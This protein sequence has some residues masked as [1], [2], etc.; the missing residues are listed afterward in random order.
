MTGTFLLA[1]VLFPVVVLVCCGGGGLLVRRLSGGELSA[2]LVVPVGF[3]LLVVVCA[4]ATSISWLAPAGGAIVLALAV[5][6]YVAEARAGAPRSCARARALL[7]RG[8]SGWLWP[9]LAALIAFAAVGGPALLTGTPTWAGYTRIVDIAFQMDFA[10]HLAEAGRS[11]AP[12]HSSF[13]VS[14]DKLTS[15]GYPGGGQATLGVMAALI[16]TDVAWC[17]QAYL[18][19]TAAIGALAAFSLLSR[20][21]RIRVLCALGAA[22]VIQPNILYGYTLEGGIKEIT[23]AALLLAAVALLVERL[24]GEGSRWSMLPAAVAISAAF[25]SFSAGVA[26]WLGL[27]LL[28]LLIVTFVRSRYRRRLLASWGLFL[29]S[30]AALSIPSFFA[31]AE[32]ASSAEVSNPSLGNLAAAV[33]DWSSAGVWLTGDYRFP[34]VHVA[35]THAFDV[36]VIALAVLGIIFALR[37]HYWALGILGLG[38]PIALYYWVASAGPWIQLKAFTITSAFALLL[39]FFGAG[40]LSGLHPRLAG[41]LGS[42][43]AVVMAGVVLYGN[44][45]IYHDTSLAPAA[46]YRDLAA[47]GSAY[48]GQGPLMFPY[49]D[50]YAEYFL[51]HEDPDDLVDPAYK[52]FILASGVSPPP[53]AVSFSWDLN[54]LSASFVQSFRLIVLARSPVANRPP[55]NYDLVKQTHYFD[56]WRRDR[57]S[58]TVV[59][60]LPLSGLP[61]ERTQQFCSAFIT[62][63]RQAGPGAE[64]AYAQSSPGTV[65]GVTQGPHPDYW[66]TVG[67]D[68]VISYGAGTAQIPVTLPQSALFDIW[69]QGSVG[70]P[71]AVYVDGRHLTNI[72]WEERYPN[73]FL[74]L[75][76]RE[77]AR[78]AHTVRIVR[79]NG[80]LHPGSGDPPTDTVGRTIGAVVFSIDDS[81]SGRVHVAPPSM[82]AQVCAAPVGYQ[83][84]EVLKPGGAPANAIRAQR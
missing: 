55:S 19:V 67:P 25:A 35:A 79:G 6:G 12:L 26:P 49:F 40:A 62:V 32:L 43:A 10:K 47:I 70:R 69:V 71:L 39:A 18:A 8:A 45:I 2:G 37:R 65:T 46:R 78:G 73:Q 20:A 64:V 51:R 60:H 28:G 42:L 34:L 52:G 33:P 27:V 48:A 16:R 77:L 61:H 68:T 4:F 24:P 36:L 9:T 76:Q 81:S 31:V 44:A 41:W 1:W 29:A 15:V 30:I 82:A 63:A 23:T 53:G 7:S 56:V 80:S 84:L 22:V 59:V 3:A 13:D 38:T 74:L 57:P 66:R 54:Q 58:S 83:W 72:G 50:E 11:V 14:L 5:V 21:I 75:G 17:Y